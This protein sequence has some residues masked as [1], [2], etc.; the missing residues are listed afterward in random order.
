MNHQRRI[1]MLCYCWPT[2]IY[3]LSTTG[4]SRRGKREHQICFPTQ[5]FFPFIIFHLLWELVA[6]LFILVVTGSLRYFF[7]FSVSFFF[8]SPYFPLLCTV[9]GSHGR[10][11]GRIPRPRFKL[12]AICL[13][14]FS[15]FFSTSYYGYHV[16]Q[17]TWRKAWYSP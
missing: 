16:Q 4:M 5:S 7:I 6:C 3:L 2:I 1:A 10:A 17:R 15:S 9:P 8:S 12:P 11:N 13:F 14:C